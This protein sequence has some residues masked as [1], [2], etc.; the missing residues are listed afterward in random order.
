[1]SAA[2]AKG[3]AWETAIVRH[4]RDNGFP[5]A[6][7]RA[8]SGNQDKGD[9]A[10]VPLVVIEAKSAKTPRWSEW[11]AELAAEQANANAQVAVLWIKR[12]GKTRA[13][14]GLIVMTPKQLLELIR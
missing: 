13:A 8:L 14:D 12:P 10:G 1:M 11:F 3:T 7:R 4:L 9:V 2:K 6:E 5:D